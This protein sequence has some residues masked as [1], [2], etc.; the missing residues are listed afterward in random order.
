MKN[1]VASIKTDDIRRW[2]ARAL[3]DKLGGVSRFAEKLGRAQA[4]MSHI[5]GKNP[6]KMIESKQARHIESACGMV[7]GWLDV[8]HVTDWLAIERRDWAAAL[9]AFLA[10]NGITVE[11]SE[12]E[13]LPEVEVMTLFRSMSVTNRRK[14]IDIARVLSSPNGRGDHQ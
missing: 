12:P 7:E 8:P 2:N 14:L 9:R 6:V 5:I 1:A 10:S 3:A 13:S 4:Q 11:S